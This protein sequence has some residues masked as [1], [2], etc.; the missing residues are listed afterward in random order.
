MCSSGDIRACCSYRT[1]STMQ[2][3]NTESQCHREETY[4]MDHCGCSDW[5]RPLSSLSRFRHCSTPFFF[6]SHRHSKGS[7]INMSSALRSFWRSV[8]TS[9]L[10]RQ[11][12]PN[13]YHLLRRDA[14]TKSPSLKSAHHRRFQR[15]DCRRTRTSAFH[16][17]SRA[18]HPE[19]PRRIKGDWNQR[20]D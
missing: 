16:R 5:S 4:Q 15:L 6:S 1:I 19:C 9:L 3:K 17:Q 13:S 12:I 2:F 18:P 10:G 8:A 7:T 20:E 14:L 11:G